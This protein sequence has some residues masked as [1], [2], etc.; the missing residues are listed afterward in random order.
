MKCKPPKKQGFQ[1]ISTVSWSSLVALFF[2]SS[3]YEPHNH[4]LQIY[5]S[6]PTRG[7]R[8]Q[9]PWMWVSI[10]LAL[11]LSDPFRPHICI[12]NE[13]QDLKCRWHRWHKHIKHCLGLR[14]QE[15]ED[16][17]GMEDNF[18]PEAGAIYIQDIRGTSASGWGCTRC[19]WWVKT[20]VL[21]ALRSAASTKQVSAVSVEETASLKHGPQI[22]SVPEERQWISWEDWEAPRHIQLYRELQAN[23]Q[24]GFCFF[25]VG[26]QTPVPI[27]GGCRIFSSW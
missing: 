9:H 19:M 4:I 20:L 7:M 6:Q 16:T 24:A 18:L 23:W 1:F 10:L 11:H 5:P 12:W 15:V 26:R 27:P 8:V 2:F 22:H 25:F 3:S 13:S 14:T 21:F 17:T